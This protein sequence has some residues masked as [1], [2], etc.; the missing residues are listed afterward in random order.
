[1]GLGAAEWVV[2]IGIT[3]WSS[4]MFLSTYFMR[5]QARRQQQLKLEL[6]YSNRNMSVLARARARRSC[7]K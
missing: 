3:I 2:L 4:G 1:M 7:K 5:D 6:A